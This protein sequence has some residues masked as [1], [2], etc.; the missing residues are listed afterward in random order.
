MHSEYL[1]IHVKDIGARHIFLPFYDTGPAWVKPSCL[2]GEMLED[3]MW[4]KQHGLLL[5]PLQEVC[6][7][8]PT[9]PKLT[10]SHSKL[11]PNSVPPQNAL[12][13]SK[14]RAKTLWIPE[15]SCSEILQRLQ[16]RSVP[17]YYGVSNSIFL[18]DTF[19]WW[20]F[21]KSTVNYYGCHAE[22][23]DRLFPQTLLHFLR[24]VELPHGLPLTT[25]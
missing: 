24:Q 15:I 18:I 10:L 6:L 13:S 11:C 5:R 25:W 20:F 19:L 2:L 23:R 8:V 12:K 7:P 17:P 3:K 1:K 21:G 22:I 14:V 4:R 16:Q 9:N